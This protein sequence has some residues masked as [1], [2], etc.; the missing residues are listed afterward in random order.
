MPIKRAIGVIGLNIVLNFGV[1]G[2][3]VISLIVPI[4]YVHGYTWIFCE[5]L[6]K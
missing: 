3:S 5:I 2:N 1:S 4:R 6:L